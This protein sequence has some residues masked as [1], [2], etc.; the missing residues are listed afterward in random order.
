[1][2]RMF[3]HCHRI[4]DPEKRQIGRAGSGDLTVA[5]TDACFNQAWLKNTALHFV[6]MTNLEILDQDPGA[7][8]YR[9]AMIS[10]G[11]LGHVLCLSA[12]ALGLAAAASALSMTTRPNRYWG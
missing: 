7:R 10:A 9:H 11:R 6:L 8:G 3:N 12:T 5:M 4:V 1:M 2:N